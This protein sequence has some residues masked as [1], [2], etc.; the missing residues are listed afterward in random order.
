MNFTRQHIRDVI[1]CKTESYK[2]DR[3]NFSETF[4]M[5]KFNKFMGADF[6]FCQDNEVI[7]KKGVVRG[8]HYQNAPFEQAKLVRAVKGS[9][10]DVAVD[11]RKD[12]PTFGEHVA[13]ELNDTN[14]FQMFIPK[15][16][17]HGYIALTEHVVVLYKVD[18]YYNPAADSGILYNDPQLR[19]D[20]R[21]PETAHIVS[22]RDRNQPLLATIE[23]NY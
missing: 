20:W 17:A 10:L 15:G 2:D 9:I 5:D 8:L 19:I 13:L 4:R 23:K 3:G 11:I 14:K 21:L 22:E 18:A 12:S 7:S 16:F 1:L 6:N